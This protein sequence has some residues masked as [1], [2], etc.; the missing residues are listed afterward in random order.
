MGQRYKALLKSGFQNEPLDETEQKFLQDITHMGTQE[1]DAQSLHAMLVAM[2]YYA[3][4]KLKIPYLGNWVFQQIKC[5]R[6]QLSFNMIAIQ[7]HLNV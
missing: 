6:L 2:L 7:T 3:P 4:G 5:L 1:G